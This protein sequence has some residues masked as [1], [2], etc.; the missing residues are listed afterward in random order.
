MNF[1]ELNVY[2]KTYLYLGAVFICIGTYFSTA[3][4]MDNIY[5]FSL[6]IF[7]ILCMGMAIKKPKEKKEQ[8]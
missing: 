7:G 5:T 3:K 8:K 2:N 1:H 4:N 6:L